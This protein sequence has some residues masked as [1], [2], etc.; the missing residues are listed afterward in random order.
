MKLEQL[1]VLRAVVETGTV[2]AAA[3]YLNKTQPA[4][5]QALKTL[6][7]Q[8]GVKLFNRSEYRLELTS[9]GKRVYLQSLRVM[10][11][12]DDLA[13]LIRHFEKGNEEQLTVAVDATVDM[14]LL[15]PALRSIQTGFPETNLILR[16]EML[17]GTL[18]SVKD[19]RADLAVAPLPLFI[20]EDSGMD[21][22]PVSKAVLRNV[23]SPDVL[24]TLP[25]VSDISD[26]RGL[27]Q[28]LISDTGKQGD[29]F[30]LEFGVQKG[31]RRWYVSD[32]ETKKQLILAGLG[33]G[34]LPDYLIRE[35][36][37]SGRLEDIQLEHSHHTMHL[38]IVAFRNPAPV[39]GPVASAF[40]DVMKAQTSDSA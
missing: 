39:I 1:K 2:K 10:N 30:S 21:Y 3:E 12:S 28:I 33:W 9:L 25:D 29:I 8:A 23:A 38:D 34:R 19:G 4:I 24:K 22:I 20:L 26:L 6:E 5:S 17:S 35:D 40:W 36:L 13:H 16:T 27:H 18:D 31:Q 11:E 14:A 7:F 32:P 37:R 15:L